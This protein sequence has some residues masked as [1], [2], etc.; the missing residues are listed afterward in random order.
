LQS[1]CE[2]QTVQVV[3]LSRGVAYMY[4]KTKKK[5]GVS[6]AFCTLVGSVHLFVSGYALNLQ[7]QM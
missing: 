4:L 2:P 3:N 6:N 7:S 5:R 1:A